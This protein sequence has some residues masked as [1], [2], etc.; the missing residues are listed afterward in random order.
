M[1]PYVN[2]YSG[3]LEW[4]DAFATKSKPQSLH[5]S[6]WG[7][8]ASIGGPPVAPAGDEKVS[9]AGA[10]DMCG[11]DSCNASVILW[12]KGVDNKIWVVD[13]FPFPVKAEAFVEDAT[14]GSEHQFAFELLATGTG[15]PTPPA[16]KEQIPTSPQKA[17]TARGDYLVELEWNP[18]EIRPDSAVT[19]GVTMTENNGFPLDN[20]D[21][22]FVV[23]DSTGKVIKELTHQKAEFGIGTHEVKFNGTGSMSISVILN[24][25]S[26]KTVGGAG[27][28]IENA[29]FNVVV[30]P[31]FPVS[32]AIIAAS[33]IG[34]VVVMTRARTSLFG[35]KTAPL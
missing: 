5:G 2:G 20:V 7:K 10:Q 9:F 22:D 24:S 1:M 26:G 19:F 4:L 28:Q 34:L 12:H 11:S 21:Y 17:K 14:G 3:S 18:A 31:E 25:I 8:I 27:G 13:N 32:A 35:G 33:V 15:Q 23:K 16:S 29:D 6:Y 30:V